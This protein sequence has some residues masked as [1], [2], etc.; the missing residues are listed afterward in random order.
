MGE[1]IYLVSFGLWIS[2]EYICTD[3]GWQ[4]MYYFQAVILTV[5]HGKPYLLLYQL[6]P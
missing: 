6:S 3:E 1:I 5:S 4:W 2:H